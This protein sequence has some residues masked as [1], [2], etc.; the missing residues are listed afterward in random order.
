MNCGN[1]RFTGKV[2]IVTGAG[3][4]IGLATAELFA[5]EGA[6][7]IAVDILADRL[8]ALQEKDQSGN[9]VTVCGDILKEDTIRG[10][11]SIANERI[12]ILANIVGIMDGFL[13]A[14]E[15]DDATWD[16]VIA[17][18]VTSI[19][20]LTRAV[21]PFMVAARKGSI[22]NIASE[23]GLR[24]SSAGAAYTTSKHAVIGLT[25]STAF[26]YAKDGIRANVV[27]PGGVKTSIE[28]PFKSSLAQERMSS[29]MQVIVPP[30]AEPEQLADVIGFLASDAASNIN[31]AVLPCDG[32]WSVI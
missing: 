13:P 29:L 28:A 11:L 10:I 22:V 3:A 21:L 2:A 8:D 1:K 30:V 25:K 14:A 26:I 19:M 17:V 27:A 6:R 7:V 20:R 31:G 24:G 9:I 16:R 18:N 32:G 23:A 15:V 12:D 5:R 4:G